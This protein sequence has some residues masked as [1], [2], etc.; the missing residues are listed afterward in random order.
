MKRLLFSIIICVILFT[1]AWGEEENTGYLSF[2]SKEQMAT[3]EKEGEISRV[4]KKDELPVFIPE[5][6]QKNRII[7]EIKENEPT[8]GVEIL[9]LYRENGETTNKG[10]GDLVSLY[11]TLQA[12]STL[13]G[14][15]YYSASR[16]RMRI[17]Y[18]DAYVIESPDNKKRKEDPVFDF[19]PVQ[20]ELFAFFK[21]SS[22]GNYVCHVE[23]F[24]S[25]GSFVME[26]ENLD[27]IWYTVVP[28]I[29]PH[30]LKSYIIIIPQKNYILFYSFSCLRTIN[31]FNMAEKRIASLY[32][33]IKAIYSWFYTYYQ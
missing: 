13:K 3:L 17:F 9:L 2:L 14:I 30:D 10:E 32:N 12:I 6:I 23:Y 20:S 25:Q 31:L 11:N 4:V 26:M 29:K 28:I 27:Q 22:F 33:R 21:D 1:S 5:M 16:E 19:V 15:E 18:K 8:I 24:Y 7:T